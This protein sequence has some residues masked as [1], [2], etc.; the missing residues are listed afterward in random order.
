[1][2]VDMVERMTLKGMGAA[3]SLTVAAEAEQKILDGYYKK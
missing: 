2:L 3:E 1:V